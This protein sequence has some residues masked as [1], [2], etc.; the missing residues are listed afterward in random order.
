MPAFYLITSI[1]PI[2]CA[3][4][5]ISTWTKRGRGSCCRGCRARLSGYLV[6]RLVREVPGAPAKMAVTLLTLQQVRRSRFQGIGPVAPSDGW[7][8]A[9][10]DGMDLEDTHSS[11]AGRGCRVLRGAIGS[12]LRHHLPLRVEVVRPSGQCAG[13]RAARVH[14]A[15][16]ES[17]AV[18]LPGGV[19]ELALSTRDLLRAGLATRPATARTRRVARRR[20]RRRKSRAPRITSISRSSS[21]NSPRSARA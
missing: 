10:K 11:G 3:E 12:P 17:R 13:H 8:L 5:R 6:P 15:R 9:M 21:S 2:A 19:H 1:Y 16:D 20:A 4:R 14:Q 7:Q 18:P